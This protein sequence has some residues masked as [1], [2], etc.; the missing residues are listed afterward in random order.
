MLWIITGSITSYLIGSIPNAYIFGRLLKGIDIRKEG[1]GNVG[2][3]NALRVLGKGPGIAVLALDIL[4]GFLA[5][6]VLGSLLAAKLSNISTESRSI[7]LGLSCICGHNWTIFLG[8]KGGKGIATTLGVLI[9]LALQIPGL[10]L[11]LLMVVITWLIV[12]IAARIVSLASVIA[13]IALPIYILLFKE[14]AILAALSILLALF[15]ILRHKSN[16]QRLLKGKEPRLS[17]K[18]D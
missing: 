7:I 10:K 8:F 1:S 14:S 4:K 6:F 9:G 12:F 17:F 16:L 11:I 3:T 2:A 13:A 15:I 18:K 5:V